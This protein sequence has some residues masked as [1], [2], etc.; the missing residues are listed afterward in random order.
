MLRELKK[1][2][3]A[4][5][6]ELVRRGLVTETW[7][8][9]SAVDRERGL[10]V[11]KPSGVAYELMKPVHM[12]VVSLATGEVIEGRLKASSD[13]ATHR[14]LYQ[15]FPGI[16]GVVH[17]HSLHATAWAQSCRDLPALGTTHAD[18]W[19]GAVPCT[20]PMKPGEIRAD[21]EHHTGRVIAERFRRLDPL[22]LPGALV[23]HHG[24][25]TWGATLEKAVENAAVLEFIARLASETFALAPDLGAMPRELLDKH[26]LRKHGQGAYYGQGGA[27]PH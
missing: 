15:E 3:C 27:D 13:T 22:A 19:H 4:A 26:F 14:V 9:A 24:P 17:T 5:N 23:A 8:N 12:V 1:R 20:R 10:V 21:Y 25:F 16:G 11:I 7:G 6:L 18:Y 2:V